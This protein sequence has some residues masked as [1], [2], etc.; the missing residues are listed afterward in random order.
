MA[1]RRNGPHLFDLIG[2]TSQPMVKPRYRS[3]MPRPKPEASDEP[4]VA[5]AEPTPPAREPVRVEVVEKQAVDPALKPVP[6]PAKP[7]P[8]PARHR[9]RVAER[10]DALKRTLSTPASRR[11]LSIAIA[12]VALVAVVWIAIG[13]LVLLFVDTWAMVWLMKRTEK[14]AQ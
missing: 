9:R 5:V 1:V 3:P 2:Q 10:F 7:A 11:T 6:Q 8:S 4:P 13:Y 14:P 12:A